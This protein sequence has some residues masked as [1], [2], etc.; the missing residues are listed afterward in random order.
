MAVHSNLYFE[1]DWGKKISL[2]I[3]ESMP[4]LLGAEIFSRKRVYISR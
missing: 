4:M 3:E 1:I 2:I